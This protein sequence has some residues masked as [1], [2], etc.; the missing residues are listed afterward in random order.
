MIKNTDVKYNPDVFTYK[1]TENSESKTETIKTVREFG[2]YDKFKYSRHTVLIDFSKSNIDDL[3]KSKS[4]DFKEKEVFLQVLIEGKANLYSYVNS[5]VSRYF[6]STEDKN[7][8]QLVFKEYLNGSRQ[9]LENNQFKQQLLMNL[10]CS[11]ITMGTIKNLDYTKSDLISFFEKY[12]QCQTG[13]FTNFENKE[14]KDLFNLNLR[15]GLNQASL[16]IEDSNSSY[17]DV[18]DLGEQTTFRFSAEAEFIMPFHKNKWAIIIEPTY[19]YFNAEKDITAYFTTQRVEVDYK[20]VELPIGIRHYFF[21]NDNAK[22]F[23]NASF[24]ID[25]F[26]KSSKVDFENNNDLEIKSNGNFALGIG[27]KHSDKYSLEFRYHTS[28][29]ILSQFTSNWNSSYKSISL[30]LGYTLF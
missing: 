26:G 9:I 5:D 24:V 20:S 3:T 10:K 29:N 22:I 11:S 2:I 28:R 13:E 12:N 7:L 1:L 17:T 27:Y 23:A 18:G 16:S 30:I 14:R 25:L 6:Y 8:E 21:L 15:L 19:H 4:P